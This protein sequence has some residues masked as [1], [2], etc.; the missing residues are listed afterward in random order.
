[1]SLQVLIEKASELG[2]LS[3]VK[4]YYLRE[5]IS[6]TNNAAELDARSCADLI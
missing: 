3:S 5:K 6:H 4:I 2:G 1:M